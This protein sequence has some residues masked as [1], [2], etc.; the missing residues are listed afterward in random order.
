M[1]SLT[2]DAILSDHASWW[3]DRK[4]GHFKFG[5]LG[6]TSFTTNLYPKRRVKRSSCVGKVTNACDFI[7][8]STPAIVESELGTTIRLIWITTVISDSSDDSMQ[9]PLWW[10]RISPLAE[11]V[12]FQ[13]GCQCALSLV[14]FTTCIDRRYGYTV[15][16][17]ITP[18]PSFG[19]KKHRDVSGDG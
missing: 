5:L 9:G 4:K 19:S 1:V 14:S 17:T 13:W 3:I 11:V 6:F 16:I 18:T 15:S 10:R 2:N 7:M 8:T 12:S